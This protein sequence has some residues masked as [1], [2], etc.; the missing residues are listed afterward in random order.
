MLDTYLDKLSGF[1]ERR[2]V[3]GYWSPLFIGGLLIVGLVAFL[4]GPFQAWHWWTARSNAA[5]IVM[6]IGSLL[7]ITALAY[8]LQALTV[9]LVRLYEGYW[10]IFFPRK[11]QTQEKK[12]QA[13]EKLKK[14]RSKCPEASRNLYFPSQ[15]AFLKPTKLGNILAASEDHARQ[16]YQIDPALWW[17]RLATLLPESFRTQME[18]ALTPLLAML[19]L[20]T[21][22]FIV[23]IS[24][25]IAVYVVQGA[26]LLVAA[27]LIVGLI[28]V[29]ICYI[30][31]V[32]QAQSYGSF[33]RAAFD[34]YRY[35]ILKQMHIPI[36]D[37][38]FEE[39]LLWDLLNQW[40]AS[41]RPPWQIQMARGPLPVQK[42]SDPFYSD[43]HQQPKAPEAQLH[44]ITLEMKDGTPLKQNNS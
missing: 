12:Q 8:L 7:G 15:A 9:P 20:C 38:L 1:F 17:P 28:L 6:G 21:I 27:I 10:P 25:S 11:E 26:W 24:S 4:V 29:R 23:T 36:P 32:Q 18:A 2:F 19:N 16:L 5:Q 40:I 22:L 13:R 35:E 41:Y 30:A 14:K 39:A 3:I 42:P 33:L 37:N 43:F 34:L 31:A 44:E